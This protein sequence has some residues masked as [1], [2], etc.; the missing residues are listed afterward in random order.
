MTLGLEKLHKTETHREALIKFLLLLGLLIAYFSYLSYEYGL[1]T[2]GLVALLTWS[3]FVLCTP[4]ADAG[5]LLDFPIRL[6]F[7]F[8]MLYSEIIVWILA[9][10]VNTYGLLFT[11]SVYEKTILTILLKKI[12][13]T[14]VPYWSIIL[15]S[16]T[17]TFLSIY[18]GDEMLDV[19][20]HRDRAKYHQHA[21]K[22]KIVA[23]ISLF[24]LIFLSYYFLLDS[25]D[26][27]IQEIK[28]SHTI[29]PLS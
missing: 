24:T 12:L 16:G 28:V 23:V 6:I 17:G 13:I 27:D 19:L 14:P 29:A 15:L 2:G 8:R 1:M 18:F 7:G 3:F 21:F 20:R 25:L 26:I 10:S 11:Q 5:F 4:V 9:I 22:L